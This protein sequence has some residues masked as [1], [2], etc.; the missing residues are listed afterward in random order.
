MRYIGKCPLCGEDIVD[1]GKVYGCTAYD[2]TDCGFM[3][4]KEKGKKN[5]TPIMAKQL[6]NEG[7]TNKV[8]NF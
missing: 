4:P 7:K 5:I 6:L 3:I 2:Y 8:K 1:K